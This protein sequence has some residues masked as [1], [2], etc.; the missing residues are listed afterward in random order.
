MSNNGRPLFTGCERV[1]A[2][3]FEIAE[4]RFTVKSAYEFVG[5]FFRNG[6]RICPVTRLLIT[7]YAVAM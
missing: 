2:C 4:G 7:A 5:D 1:T 6:F 3:L